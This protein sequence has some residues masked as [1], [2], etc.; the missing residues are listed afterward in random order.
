MLARDPQPLFT[1]CLQPP[2]DVIQSVF[3]LAREKERL[4]GTGISVIPKMFEHVDTIYSALINYQ[5][6]NPLMVMDLA[7]ISWLESIV[8]RQFITHPEDADNRDELAVQLRY[9]VAALGALTRVEPYNTAELEQIG[10]GQANFYDPLT[11]LVTAASVAATPE[12]DEFLP[13]FTNQLLLHTATEEKYTWEEGFVLA[14][15]IRTAWMQFVRLGETGQALLL[16]YY[17]YAGLVVGAPIAM[18][19]EYVINAG[20]PASEAMDKN[21]LYMAALEENKEIV[22]LRLNASLNRS[23]S[24]IFKG[25]ETKFVDESLQEKYAKD[26]AAQ[27]YQSSPSALS[28][29]RW[30][31]DTMLIFKHIYEGDWLPQ[32]VRQSEEL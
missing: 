16:Q 24:T 30:L 19:L 9:V 5:P 2:Q 31:E 3:A 28:F 26:Y 8:I 22:P 7:A 12:P 17:F 29:T 13:F 27:L 18:I 15:M 14:V 23:L 21:V 11:L 10:K 32:E 25:Y 20:V 4:V 6:S 1:F